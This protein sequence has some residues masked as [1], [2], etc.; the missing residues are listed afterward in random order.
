MKTPVLIGFGAACVV[1]L[2]AVA[3]DAQSHRVLVYSK[4]TMFRHASITNGIAAIRQ[5][6]AAN[7]FAVDAT[8]DS[9]AFTAENLARYRAVVFL[10][11]SGDI[12]NAEQQ[13]ALRTYLEAGG[14]LAGVHAAVAGK[15]ATEGSWPWYVKL[16]CTEFTN[17]SAIVEAAIDVE[18]AANAST[19]TLPK[20][21]VRTDEWYNFTVNPRG[22]VRVLASLD[23]SS[24]KGGTMGRDHP[25]AWCRSIGRGRFWYTALGHTEASYT[26]PKFLEHL[27]GGIQIAAGIKSANFTPNTK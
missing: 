7:A 9:S 19:A 11:T 18:D 26:E 20:R 25:I 24:Y 17:H 27:L 21:W 16:N 6:G 2:S 8:E 4:T 13:A 23:E 5:L 12:L 1:A 22:Q 15:V 14:G 3:A 10:N